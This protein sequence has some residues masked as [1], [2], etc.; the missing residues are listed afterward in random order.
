MRPSEWPWRALRAPAAA[1]AA[2]TLVLASTV[3][4]SQAWLERQQRAFAQARQSLARAATR[5]RSASDDRAVYARYANRF[6]DIRARGWIGEARRVS[7]IEALQRSNAELELP[8]LRY[9]IGRQ[10]RVDL[11]A[12]G[13]AAEG[14]VLQGTPMELTLDAL[15]EG[16]VITLLQ[17][18]AE[19]GD[20]LMALRGCRLEHA[21]D[22]GRIRLDPEAAN[23]AAACTL[24][25]Y[26]LRI[27]GKGRGS[28]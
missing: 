2:A 5:Y 1:V 4:V 15:H 22:D 28:S 24:N 6:R 14:L 18:L 7:W 13:P 23:V 17:R 25:W 10:K 3:Y 9:D 8:R 26:T 21:G 27:E 16:D 19:H 11:G 20:G 12:T